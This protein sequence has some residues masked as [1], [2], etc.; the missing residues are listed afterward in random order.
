MTPDFAHTLIGHHGSPLLAYDLA[1]VKAR[2]TSLLSAI[3]P[4]SR[5]FYSLKA[6]PLPAI[7]RAAREA[8]AGAEVT[9]LGEL[10]AALQA[11]CAAADLLL[12]GPGKTTHEIAAAL[13]LGVRWF[14]CES[15]TD[16]RRLSAATTA[17]IQAAIRQQLEDRAA[18]EEGDV[19]EA[20]LEESGLL[21]DLDTEAFLAA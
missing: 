4:G 18:A 14:S 10:D 16:A 19:W 8:G 7:V 15:F 17:G 21:D 11:G 5:L 2:V 12:G 1:A 6:N 9:S 20:A 3:P 13:H